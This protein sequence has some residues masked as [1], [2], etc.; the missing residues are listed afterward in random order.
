MSLGRIYKQGGTPRFKAHLER[1]RSMLSC[2]SSR[3]EFEERIKVI[4]ASLSL[5]F[6][7]VVLHSFPVAQAQDYQARELVIELED[8]LAT[9]AQLTL[10]DRMSPPGHFCRSPIISLPGALQSCGSTREGWG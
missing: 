7:L 1:Y 2:N 9:D 8:G 4:S 5:I 10:R 6:I 3:L